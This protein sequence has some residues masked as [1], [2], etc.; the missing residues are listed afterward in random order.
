MTSTAQ[1]DDPVS[2]S[3]EPAAPVKPVHSVMGRRPGCCRAGPVSAFREVQKGDR[4]NVGGASQA[5][6]PM[7]KIE[8]TSSRSS[9]A[10]YCLW[11]AV[12]PADPV[13]QASSTSSRSQGRPSRGPQYSNCSWFDWQWCS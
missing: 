11:P 3:P 4:A 5:S 2:G 8:Q 7:G 6:S 10:S 12:V 9:P 13:Y 1:M